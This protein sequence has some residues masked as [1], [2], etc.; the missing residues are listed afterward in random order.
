MDFADTPEQAAFRAQVRELIEREL[1]ARYRE[2]A[3]NGRPE[4]SFLWEEDRASDD[5]AKRQ[6][7]GEWAESMRARGWFA[8]A[9]PTKYG[10]GGLGMLEQFVLKQEM[11][12]ADAPV[13]A[14]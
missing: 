7:S 1:P 3:M 9:W 14:A 4:T 11:A 8:P 10:G 5:P 6:A 13:Q 2:L 12:T